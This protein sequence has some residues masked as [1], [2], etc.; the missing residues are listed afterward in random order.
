M[1]NILIGICL[2]P[3]H[4]ASAAGEIFATNVKKEINV[5]ITHKLNGTSAISQSD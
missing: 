4:A 5:Q 2:Y 3:E 1:L